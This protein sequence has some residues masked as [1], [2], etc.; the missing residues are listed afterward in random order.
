L[1]MAV[2]N[3]QV[4]PNVPQMSRFFTSVGAALQVA[5]EGRS[6]AEAALQEAKANMLRP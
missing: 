3:G 2:E 5:T 6:S 4:M 1:R